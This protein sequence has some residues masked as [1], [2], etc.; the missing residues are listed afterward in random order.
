MSFL[1]IAKRLFRD[2]GGNTL[3]VAAASFP[4]LLGSAGMAIDT[5]QLVLKKRELQRTADSAALAGAYALDQDKPVEAAVDYTLTL[6]KFS[7]SDSRIVE[8]APTKGA[9]AGDNQA[10]RVVLSSQQT[11]PFMSLFMGHSSLVEAEATAAIVYDGEFCVLALEDQNATGVSFQGNATV[12]LGCGIASNSTSNAAISASGSSSV[13]ASP[14]TARGGVPQ[15]GHYLGD[16]VYRPHS[17]L[18]RDPYEQIPT[19]SPSKCSG[20]INIGPKAKTSIDPGCYKSMDIKGTVTFSPG[21]YYIDGGILNIGAQANVTG[22]GVTI[23]LTSTTPSNPNSFATMDINGGATLNLSAPTS[24]SYEG[25]LFYRDRRAPV[26]TTIRINGNA[27]S[28]LEGSI[29][30]P[31]TDIDFKGTA[32]M[33]TK[34]VQFIGR[35][36]SFSGNSTIL[37]QCPPGAGP[38]GFKGTMVRLVA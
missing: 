12:N 31:T 6:N 30:F 2:R 21:T 28:S 29:Y 10:V 3:I 36:V 13:T 4:L 16:T 18:Q 37:N 22:Q 27:S 35:R 9:Y 8:N 17:P 15:S 1:K 25:V 5:V 20:S 23:V 34:C 14:I 26:G 24:G 38:Q 19:P 33:E 32:G 7:P 11:M